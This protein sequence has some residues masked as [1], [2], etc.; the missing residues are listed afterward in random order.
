MYLLKI[1][2]MGRERVLAVPKSLTPKV[3]AEYMAVSMDD[4]GRLVYTPIEV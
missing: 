1:R 4:A 2:K 3:T